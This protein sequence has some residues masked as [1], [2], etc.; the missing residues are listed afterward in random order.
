MD[1]TKQRTIL[2]YTI[3][4]LI[5]ASIIWVLVS[6]YLAATITIVTDDTSNT[7]LINEIK[8]HKHGVSVSQ[9][10]TQA[11]ARV[12]SGTYT[13]TV[14]S[15]TTTT[16]ILQMVTVGVG[17]HKSLTMNLRT[18]ASVPTYPPP[19]TSM[20]ASYVTASSDRVSFIDRSDANA[21][22]YSVDQTGHVTT[23]D[24]RHIYTSVKWADST[25]GIGLVSSGSVNYGLEK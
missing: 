24:N 7:V 10:G 16:S 22:L 14:K 17:E 2:I 12:E 8:P 9:S 25:F 21:P 19:V 11:S 1:I 15:S 18:N 6:F 3:L 23:L 5:A 4:G 20:G 13:V